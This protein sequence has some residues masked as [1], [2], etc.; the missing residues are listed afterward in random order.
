MAKPTSNQLSQHVKEVVQRA[1]QEA[2]PKDVLAALRRIALDIRN[3]IRAKTKELKEVRGQKLRAALGIEVESGGDVDAAER[4]FHTCE[5][6]E[7]ELE[8]EIKVLERK[9]DSYVREHDNWR[10]FEGRAKVTGKDIEIVR[11][12]RSL[13]RS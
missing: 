3:D 7:K 8:L 10:G 4:E 2:S 6:R 11:Q 13:G 9:E 1:L 12:M 5:R